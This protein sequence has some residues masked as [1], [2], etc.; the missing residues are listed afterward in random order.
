[1]KFFVS[2][3]NSVKRIGVGILKLYTQFVQ[4]EPGSEVERCIVVAGVGLRSERQARLAIEAEQPDQLAFDGGIRR[5][6]DK[7][8]R[9]V[10]T[11]GKE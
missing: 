7:Q 6:Y 5:N 10:W 11:F 9:I 3:E 1:M 4:N 8:Q 2:K